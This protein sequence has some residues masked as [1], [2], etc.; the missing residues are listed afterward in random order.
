MFRYPGCLLEWRRDRY[1]NYTIL[2]LGSHATDTIHKSGTEGQKIKKINHISHYFHPVILPYLVFVRT[3][4]SAKQEAFIHPAS[5]HRSPSSAAKDRRSRLPKRRTK[6][7]N[8]H[9]SAC[10]S[11]MGSEEKKIKLTT[12]QYS[13]PRLTLPPDTHL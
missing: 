12:M 7:S 1:F 9:L 4:A 3:N 10:V 5:H 13:A 11:R 8:I 6:Y 2:A